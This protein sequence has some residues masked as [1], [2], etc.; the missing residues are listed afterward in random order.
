MDFPGYKK[1]EGTQIWQ[2]S[3][4]TMNLL[5]QYENYQ[6][7]SDKTVAKNFFTFAA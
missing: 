6:D 7:L 2:I 1:P 5:Y 3:N 4:H